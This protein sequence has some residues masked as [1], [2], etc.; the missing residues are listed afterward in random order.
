[1]NDANEKII[2]LEEEL[3]ESKQIQLDLLEQLNQLTVKH[4]TYVSQMEQELLEMEKQYEQDFR[5]KLTYAQQKI[6]ELSDIIGK[7][8]HTQVIYIAHRTCK[9]D[10]AVAGFVNKYPERKKLNI[11]FLR[12]SEGVYK[13]GQKRVYIKIEKGNKLL[14]RVGGGFMGIEEFIHTYR[15]EEAEKINRNDMIGRWRNK[16]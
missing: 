11:M 15:E 9:I 1:M 2:Q 5:H 13:F 16:T 7:L 12:E 14:V 8:E 3:Y 4:E 10:Q 6:A